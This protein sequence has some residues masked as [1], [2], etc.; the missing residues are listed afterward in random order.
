MIQLWKPTP[1][2][3]I[4]EA[5]GAVADDRV[6]E[7][8]EAEAAVD[9]SDGSKTYTVT[10]DAESRV[11]SSNDNASFWQGY[12]GYPGVAFLMRAGL[13]P[14]DEQLAAGLKGVEWKT[15]N[16]KLRDHQKVIRHLEEHA[17]LDA[18]RA[19][20]FADTVRAAMRELGLRKPEKRPRAAKG[21]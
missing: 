1:A 20:R 15:L 14:F 6:R 7:V 8:N 4:L 3:K 10:W 9:S 12:L 18:D 19:G 5:L 17:G 11:V 21:K 13:L 16:K 2:L